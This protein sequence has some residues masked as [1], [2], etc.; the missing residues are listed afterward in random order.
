MAKVV[1]SAGE[2]KAAIMMDI[3]KGIQKATD[4]GAAYV[5]E[6]VEEDVYGAYSPTSY[7]RT[8]AFGE[9]D[10]DVGLHG[11]TAQGE[12]TLHGGVHESYS[13]QALG[14]DASAH[15]IMDTG[16]YDLWGNGGAFTQPRGKWWDSVEE[17]MKSA[18]KF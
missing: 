8:R 6:R 2:L 4:E 13:G 7:E 12:L 17:H 3:Q 10:Q 9:T 15:I 14:D 5:R 11:F 18:F 16:S 1:S